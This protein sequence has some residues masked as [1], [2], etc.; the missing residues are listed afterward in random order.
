MSGALA[1]I[2]SAAKD[3]CVR[4]ARPFAALRVTGL[5]S[6]CLVPGQGAL[7]VPGAMGT[8][9]PGKLQRPV[10]LLLAIEFAAPQAAH[11]F[12]RSQQFGKRAL[13]IDFAVF[14]D[15]DVIG[16]L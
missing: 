5:L 16:T 9:T 7:N 8:D 10:L 4:R 11:L 6:R 1:V 14:V 13:R 3:L 2:L 12:V 15:D